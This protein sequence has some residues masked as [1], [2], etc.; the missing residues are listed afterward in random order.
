[1]RGTCPPGCSPMSEAHRAQCQRYLKRLYR[2][3]RGRGARKARELVLLIL[4]ALE[5]CRLD[6][7]G[8]RQE[9]HSEI[10]RM[11][12]RQLPG[13]DRNI[14]DCLDLL[15]K[16]SLLVRREEGTRCTFL[17][18]QLHDPDSELMRR[19]AAEEAAEEARANASPPPLATADES[20]DP[21]S[22]VPRASATPPETTGPETVTSASPAAESTPSTPDAPILPESKASETSLR[23]FT[24]A[25]VAPCP[26]GGRPGGPI[27]PG[28]GNSRFP[29]VTLR[30]FTDVIHDA[31]VPGDEGE[32]QESP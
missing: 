20:A 21:T 8:T 29:D 28:S 14:R 32:D 19:I 13:G 31:N 16:C 15:V 4:E 10:M 26:A 12:E 9:V 18:G 27:I 22:S 25:S 3:L 7:T 24:D 23:G 2:R 1:V 5:W 17:F 6:I 11:L 30:G